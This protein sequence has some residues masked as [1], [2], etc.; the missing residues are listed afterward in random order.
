[1][2][3]TG[4]IEICGVC[5]SCEGGVCRLFKGKFFWLKIGRIGGR[6][7]EEFEGR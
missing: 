7:V 5:G 1:M 2:K 3:V 4:G 6:R